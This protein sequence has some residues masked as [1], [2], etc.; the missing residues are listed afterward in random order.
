M[1]YKRLAIG[2][3][4]HKRIKRIADSEGISMGEL[5]DRWSKGEVATEPDTSRLTTEEKDAIKD[6]VDNKM[7]SSISVSRQT[8]V[9]IDILCKRYNAR[10]KS[11]LLQSIALDSL[12]A[13]SKD[14]IYRP[15]PDASIDSLI[16]PVDK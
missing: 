7:R 16:T 6:A 2:E 13:L 4:T 14:Y 8:M 5:V 9:T 11:K 1:V 10:N 12:I 15:R 3:E